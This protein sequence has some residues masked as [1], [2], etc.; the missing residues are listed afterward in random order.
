MNY[1]EILEVSQNA[2]PEVIK[3]AYKS[4]M[5]RYHPDRNPDNPEIAKHA[6]LVVQAYEVL[7]DTDMRAAYNISLKLELTDNL[8]SNRN[9]N[10]DDKSKHASTARVNVRENKSQWFVW[11]I[12]IVIIS[13]GWLIISIL[14][15]KQ[16]SE[17]EKMQTRWSLES[18]QFA[19]NKGKGNPEITAMNEKG[20]SE[21][22]ESYS[23][24]SAIEIASR[25]V[26]VFISQLAVNLKGTAKTP[27]VEVHTLSIPM[28]GFI[29][30]TSDPDKIIQHIQNRKAPI[31]QLLEERL[32]YAKY[33]ELI[34][35]DGEQY[36]KKVIWDAI[37]E[38][39]GTD[40]N[41]ESSTQY[42]VVEVLLPESF[43]V[44]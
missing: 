24:K 26:P 34:K 35:I 21:E 17:P 28:V 22:N 23:S 31:G 10:A 3:A 8:N 39:T 9:K 33:E 5:Q 41:I 19:Q 15:K 40:R 18:N 29:V 13:S 25:T 4:L 42:G 37:G 44:K 38:A 12:I 6:S 2:S 14:K 30:G 1:Y 11:L 43:S 20:R 7:S 16:S 32:T 36:L 27:L